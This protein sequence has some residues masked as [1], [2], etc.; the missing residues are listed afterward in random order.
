[1]PKVKCCRIFRGEN[2]DRRSD[3]RGVAQLRGEISQRPSAVSAVKIGG[4]RAYQ[5]AREGKPVELAA[6]VVRVD[7]FDLLAIRRDGPFL[8]VDVEVDCSSGTYIRALARDLGAALG[9]GGH[10]TALRRTGSAATGWTTPAPWT[11]WPR[12]V[13]E[14][15]PRRGLPAGLPRRDITAEQAVDAGHGN[16]CPQQ[17]STASTRPPIP[18]GGSSHCCKTG[19]R[20]PSP[21]W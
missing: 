5:L 12:P 10:L 11:P 1:M 7:R 3:R 14:L 4:K 20:A 6:R 9:V 13:A 21:W 18:A 8:D 2:A 17:A 19:E 16:G 15:Q